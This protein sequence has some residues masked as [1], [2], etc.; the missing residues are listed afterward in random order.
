M[1]FHDLAQKF[2]AQV[3]RN[4]N[5]RIKECQEDILCVTEDKGNCSNLI[6]PEGT[7]LVKL[8]LPKNTFLNPGCQVFIKPYCHFIEILDPPTELCYDP[9]SKDIIAFVNIKNNSKQIGPLWSNDNINTIFAFHNGCR[10][11]KIFKVCKI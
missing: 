9:K 11:G 10:I 3:P 7:K 6:F 4:I 1:T 5:D 8:R 2:V